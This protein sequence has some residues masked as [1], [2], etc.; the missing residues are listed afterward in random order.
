MYVRISRIEAS[1]LAV[2][3]VLDVMYTTIN[4]FDGNF[5]LTHNQIPL[6]GGVTLV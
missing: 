6:L 2:E 4:G 5:E 3:G 1:I